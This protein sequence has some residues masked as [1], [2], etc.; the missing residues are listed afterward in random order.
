MNLPST[1][2]I[3]MT[4]VGRGM[5][6]LVN[7]LYSL[8]LSRNGHLFICKCWKVNCVL[9]VYCIYVCSIVLRY[10]MNSFT[11]FFAEMLMIPSLRTVVKFPHVLPLTLITLITSLRCVCK[12]NTYE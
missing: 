7:H 3:S 9:N 12:S 4:A 8:N 5:K 10:Y 1:L 6:V 11:Y 2:M